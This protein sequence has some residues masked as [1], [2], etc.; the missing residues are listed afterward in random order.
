MWA[1]VRFG[2]IVRA[3]TNT[4]ASF[5]VV[6]QFRAKAHFR[7]RLGLDLELDLDLGLWLS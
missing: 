4:R 5:R 7:S 6:P 3:R 1:S 2:V